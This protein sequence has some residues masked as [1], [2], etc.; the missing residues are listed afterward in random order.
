MTADACDPLHP[1]WLEALAVPAAY[2]HSVARIER[3]ETHLSWVFL[4]GDWVYKFKKPLHFDFVD[5]STLEKRKA[6][7]DD[8]LRLNQRT[9]AELY[10]EV[11]P[12]VMTADGPRLGASGEIL[13]FAV[14]M[15]QFPQS[16][17]LLNLTRE[18]RLTDDM[19][20]DLS[21]EL[22]RLHTSAARATVAMGYA[23]PAGIATDVEQCF[24][25]IE[26][27]PISSASE[28]CLAD[29]RA[30]MTVES[31]R[32][33]MAFEERRRQ[34]AIGNATV[35]CISATWCLLRASETIRLPGIQPVAALD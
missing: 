5:F 35:T 31:R 24:T 8:E 15:R 16:H 27:A 6:A 20:K 9:A 21:R 22:S 23:T 2:P 7:C 10:V 11:M 25:V 13:E 33:E 3:L 30:T 12:L 26:T 1:E 19:V 28:Q 17:L 14:R 4:T 34:G 32:L 29:L 18:G